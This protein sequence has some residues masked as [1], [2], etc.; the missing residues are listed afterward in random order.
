MAM[1]K[2]I[3]A[4]KAVEAANKAVSTRRKYGALLRV[5]AGVVEEWLAMLLRRQ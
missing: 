3:G 4:A 2:V 1:D 5:R